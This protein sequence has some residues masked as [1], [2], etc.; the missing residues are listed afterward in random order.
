MLLYKDASSSPGASIE[1]VDAKT[2][3]V[4]GYFSVFGNVDSDGDMSYAGSI[5]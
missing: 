4:T 5:Y 2:G 3:T 1:G